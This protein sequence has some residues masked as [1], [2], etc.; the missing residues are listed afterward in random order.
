MLQSVGG[1]LMKDTMSGSTLDSPNDK[2]SEADL[3]KARD[4]LLFLA[5][6]TIF[7]PDNSQDMVAV[8]GVG[9]T[10]LLAMRAESMGSIRMNSR[11]SLNSL[12]LRRSSSESASVVPEPDESPSDGILL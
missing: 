7:V 12:P 10:E 5:S 6:D 2:I 11:L 3:I 9:S 1:L 8:G 4:A